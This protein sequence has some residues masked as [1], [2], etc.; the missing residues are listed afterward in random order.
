MMTDSND[1]LFRIMSG[2]NMSMRRE[3][4]METGGLDESFNQWGG[5]DNEFGYRLY[6]HGALVIPDRATPAWHQGAGHIPDTDEIA[7]LRQQRSKMVHLIADRTFRRVLPGR[8]FQVPF[9]VVNLQASEGPGENT[10]YSIESLLAN[11]WHDLIVAV[12]CPENYEDYEWLTR[13]F[14]GDPRVVVGSDIGDEELWP[15]S[16]VRIS[17]PGGVHLSQHSIGSMVDELGARGVGTLYVTIPEGDSFTNLIV[18][19]TTRSLRRAQRIAE[20]EEQIDPVAGELFGERWDSGLDHG[21]MA[22][23]KTRRG[24]AASGWTANG[25]SHGLEQAKESISDRIVGLERKVAALR[26]RKMIRIADAVGSAIRYGVRG[27]FSEAARLWRSSL[28]RSSEAR[29]DED[30]IRHQIE[31][32]LL[33]QKRTWD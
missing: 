7:S 5:E 13:Q 30:T 27:H 8:S 12:H 28:N 11:R 18:A 24:T 23:N 19:R 10:M 17:I 2:G 1:D 31:K 20:G 32:I 9:V 3:L 25:N 6:T 15:F 16:P 14:L 22:A 33:S 4:F 26:N 21:I 29:I